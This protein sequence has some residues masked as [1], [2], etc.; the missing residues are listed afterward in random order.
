MRSAPP[1]EPGSEVEFE[2]ADIGSRRSFRDSFVEG[3]CSRTNGIALGF[4]LAKPARRE[5]DDNTAD[6]AITHDQV[7]TDADGINRNITR[8]LRQ[9][10]RSSSSAGV[11]R[12]CAGPPTRNHVSG[13]SDSF[14]S[15]RPRRSGIA[16]FRSALISG[17][18]TRL[19]QRL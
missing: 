14:A 12:I 18:L 11:N 16:T 13:A 1:I 8:Q 4:H 9:K 10:A 3:G 2:A 6:A 7:R 15:N 19:P 17:K 5:T